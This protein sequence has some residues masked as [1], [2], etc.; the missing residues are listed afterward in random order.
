MVRGLCVTLRDMKKP[1]ENGVIRFSSEKDD[2]KFSVEN[3]KR[4][5][6]AWVWGQLGG[7][8]RLCRSQVGHVRGEKQRATSRAV[9]QGATWRAEER[10]ANDCPVPS[11]PAAGTHVSDGDET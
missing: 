4:S 7:Y 3:S 5:C 8:G 6:L 2:S 11:G 1:T 10:D 9:P